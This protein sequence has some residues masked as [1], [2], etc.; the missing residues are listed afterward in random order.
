[1]V[2]W[3]YTEAHLIFSPITLSTREKKSP[4]FLYLLYIRRQY[5]PAAGRRT[6]KHDTGLSILFFFRLWS[7]LP[8]RTFY[9]CS[10][11]GQQSLYRSFPLELLCQRVLSLSLPFFSLSLTF[12]YGYHSFCLWVHLAFQVILS[13]L[14]GFA[15][16]CFFFFFCSW[17]SM[18]DVLSSNLAGTVARYCF[19]EMRLQELS[20]LDGG[21]GL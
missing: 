10:L 16:L 19:Y 8:C 2:C 15:P 5:K 20:L 12:G 17:K 6:G 13:V 11:E 9:Q 21:L 14:I 3:R 4:I 18:G 1:M 7:E